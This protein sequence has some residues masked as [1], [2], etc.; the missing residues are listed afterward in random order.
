MWEDSYTKYIIAN[1]FCNG[2][3]QGWFN[4][5]VK[6]C[7]HSSQNRIVELTQ[8]QVELGQGFI[9]IKRFYCDTFIVQFENSAACS[10]ID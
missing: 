8:P 4:H 5:G 6:L 9:V 7:K 1:I 10:T 3:T 2:K